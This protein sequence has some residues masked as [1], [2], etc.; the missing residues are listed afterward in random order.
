MRNISQYKIL[1]SEKPYS[2]YLETLN[3]NDFK[4]KEISR[5]L[6]KTVTRA[7]CADMFFI[8]FP[9]TRRVSLPALIRADES[10]S[11]LRRISYNTARDELFLADLH[12]AVVR[13]G[14]ASARQRRR[15]ARHVSARG[16]CKM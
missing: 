4:K 16:H 14:G 7:N 3:N 8:L 12:N 10:D 15:H 2:E 1:I 11:D 5:T 9:Y 13:A 6:C